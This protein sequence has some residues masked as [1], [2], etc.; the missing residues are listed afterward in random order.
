MCKWIAELGLAKYTPNFREAHICGAALVALKQ[1]HLVEIGVHSVGHRLRIL[2]SIYNIIEAQGIDTSTD[3]YIPPTVAC[4]Q[5]EEAREA[6]AAAVTGKTPSPTSSNVPIPQT[7][8]GPS[9]EMNALPHIIELFVMRDER[10]SVLETEVR[11][12]FDNYA[13]LS[14]NYAKLREELLPIF[15]LAKE[16]KVSFYKMPFLF[17]LHM[18]KIST[19]L[20]LTS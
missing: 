11:S 5:Q 6:S 3:R 20:R 10:I 19:S 1:R 9:A 13:K 18:Y 14:E 8:S 7:P 12:L 4:F 17:F 16:S 15:R 2:K